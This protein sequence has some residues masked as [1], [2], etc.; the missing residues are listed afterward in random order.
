MHRA[1]SHML[2]GFSLL[3]PSL[4]WAQASLE[5][6]AP[7]SF[8]SG[9]G[10]VSGWKC[11][12]GNLT[13]TIDN[14][15]AAQLVYGTSRLD[16]Q[17]VCGHSNTGFAFLINWNLVGTGQHTI[18]V[19]DNGQQFAQA[20]FL[21]ATLGT[22]FLRGVAREEVVLAFPQSNATTYLKWQESSQNFVIEAAVLNTI[23]PD[24]RGFYN[25]SGSETHVG[26]TDPTKNGTNSYQAQLPLILQTGPDFRGTAPL[27]APSGAF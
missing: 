26:C 4:V 19:Y 10:I 1:L 17:S 5:N 25:I 2:V 22:E 15:P 24:I 3:F 23:F 11:T 13:F 9:I 27:H 14:G 16:T 6:P 18:R 8:Q 21:V 12:A 20:P 7:N